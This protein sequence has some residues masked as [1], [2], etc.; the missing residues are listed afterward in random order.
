MI[1]SLKELENRTVQATDGQVGEVEDFYFDD[2]NWAVRYLAVDSKDWLGGQR[3]LFSPRAFGKLEAAGES[4]QVQVDR[5]T[6]R[7]SPRFE[8]N[9]PLRREQEIELHEYYQWPFYWTPG[10]AGG[11]GPGSIAAYPLVELADEMMENS[12]AA[13]LDHH[14]LHS[15]RDF[16]GFSIHARDGS[17]GRVEDLIAEDEGWN[18][19][20]M[21]VDTGG[22]LP[23]RKVLVSP[24]WVQEIDWPASQ[25]Q[26][27]LSQETIRNSPEYD[28]SVPLDQEYETR[29]NRHYGKKRER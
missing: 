15:A 25:V 14:A 13:P 6:I 28:P 12:A 16:I 8:R 19:L 26:V 20:Y 17:I 7:S 3:L 18:I 24:N 29:L 22:W 4:L 1:R 10:D 27:D 23:G 9:Q 2:D 5:E 11:L 21:I